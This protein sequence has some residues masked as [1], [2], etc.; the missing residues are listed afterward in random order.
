MAAEPVQEKEG[1]T[2]VAEVETEDAAAAASAMAARGAKLSELERLISDADDEVTA[3]KN[4]NHGP[5]TGPLHHVKRTG[6]LSA[7]QGG[8]RHV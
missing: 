1:A 4:T 7:G 5:T 2:E 8:L 3:D 6:R